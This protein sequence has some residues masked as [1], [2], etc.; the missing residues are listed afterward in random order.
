MHKA[1]AIMQ[2]PARAAIEEQSFAK[3]ALSDNTRAS[4]DSFMQTLATLA[5]DGGFDL[6][7]MTLQKVN[8]LGGVLK[9]A[10]YR[11]IRNYLERYRLAHIRERWEW[12]AAL[13][14][15]FRGACRAAIRGQGPPDRAPP[16]DLDS[17]GLQEQHQQ[18]TR[19]HAPVDIGAFVLVGVWWLLREIECAALRLDS[20]EHGD[21]EGPVA[22][23]LGVT[24]TDIQGRG[25]VRAHTCVCATSPSWCAICP[26]CT[27][28]RQFR[29]R[30]RET[31][32][33]SAPLFPGVEGSATTKRPTVAAM[34]EVAKS[35]TDG[36]EVDG[37]SMRRTGAQLMAAAGVQPWQIEWFGRWGS[38]AIR[39]YIEDARALAPDAAGLAV[40]VVLAGAPQAQP[41][42]APPPLQDAEGGREPG[43]AQA[44]EAAAGAAGAS[45]P[46]TRGEEASSASAARRFAPGTEVVEVSLP[47]ARTKTHLVLSVVAAGTPSGRTA[48]CG[49][50]FGRFAASQLSIQDFG[51]LAAHHCANCRRSVR[52]A[53]LVADQGS[54][55]AGCASGSQSTTSSSSDGDSGSEGQ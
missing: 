26:A 32:D 13:S 30:L 33:R 39:A 11:A 53:G 55:A 41:G 44:A 34:R 38:S 6:L 28:R 24:K 4:Y 17:F 5:A 46:D 54:A 2:D 15:E 45:E 27:L 3:A 48:M 22:I 35:T 20:V 25:A 51:Q 23:R 29:K 16:I 12:T 8:R 21:S 36:S 43:P 40:Q 14:I 49:W 37:H 1:R 42:D 7:P 52:A 18:R 19:V 50:H 47:L 10:G 9:A 31:P